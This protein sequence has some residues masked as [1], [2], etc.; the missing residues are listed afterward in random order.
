M[1]RPSLSHMVGIKEKYK[2]KSNNTNTSD[3]YNTLN[4]FFLCFI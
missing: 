1:I 4:P 3:V 2:Y